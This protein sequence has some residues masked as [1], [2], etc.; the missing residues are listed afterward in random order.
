MKNNNNT[1]FKM[2]YSIL[3]M[4]L[5]NK[6]ML[7][8]GILRDMAYFNG[9]GYIELSQPE[10]AEFINTDTRTARRVVSELKKNS[11]L[12]VDRRTE[13]GNRYYIADLTQTD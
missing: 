10:I 8:Y 13:K 7:L 3:R 12:R 9:E 1:W 11:L 5:S 2:P 4:K 6:A